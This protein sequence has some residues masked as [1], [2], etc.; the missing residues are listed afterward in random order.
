MS[1]L[2]SVQDDWEETAEEV[3]DLFLGDAEVSFA[4]AFFM[5]TVY[6][7]NPMRGAL[8]S[9]FCVA[10]LF[11]RFIGCRYTCVLPKK[12]G[13]LAMSA[14]LEV[15][16]KKETCFDPSPSSSDI[17]PLFCFQQ[18]DLAATNV[19]R[20]RASGWRPSACDGSGPLCAGRRLYGTHKRSRCGYYNVHFAP[21]ASVRDSAYR[22]PGHS[23]T[24]GPSISCPLVINY[25]QYA[26][27]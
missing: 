27:I 18:S 12:S 7:T 9:P 3:D 23:L 16:S 5:A 19:G 10:F 4:V 1:L 20:S 15:S 17:T 11:D 8:L 22:V 2:W 21:T 14:G 13:K 25:P 6:C 24:S 26:P